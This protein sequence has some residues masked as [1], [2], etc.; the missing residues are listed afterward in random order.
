M[1][2]KTLLLFSFIFL[3]F[4]CNDATVY[5]KIDDDFANNRWQK[6]DAKTYE[7]AITDVAPL[8]NV[9]LKFS[10]VYDFQFPQVPIKVQI[11]DPS[12]KEENFTFN[13]KIKDDAGKELGDCAGDICDLKFKMKDKIKLT[14][15]S[16]IITISNAF[17][18][19]YLPNVLAVGLN[20][21]MSK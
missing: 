1:K 9:V 5:S 13:L 18:K 8:Y 16:Y 7:F 10:H 4:S 21:E 20:V 19:P 2:A 17:D 3:L 15:G 11:K 6:T 12:G 14:K